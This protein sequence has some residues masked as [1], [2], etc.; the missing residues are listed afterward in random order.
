MCVTEGFIKL[1]TVMKKSLKF[2]LIL[3][4]IPFLIYKAKKINS[5]KKFKEAILNFMKTYFGS[6]M[7]MSS[8]VAGNKGVLC[9]NNYINGD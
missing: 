5:R 9:I 8:L 7:F 4:M 1:I 3:H 2:Y 6:L